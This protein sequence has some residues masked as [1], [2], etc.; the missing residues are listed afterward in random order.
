[1]LK[2]RYD[3]GVG[4]YLCDALHIGVHRVATVDSLASGQS[5]P[6]F[7]HSDIAVVAHAGDGRG[8]AQPCQQ[9]AMCRGGH[10]RLTQRAGYVIAPQHA[11][12]DPRVGYLQMGMVA[13]AYHGEQGGVVK[14]HRVAL[15][16]SR[17]TIV[18]AL[19]RRQDGNNT[20]YINYRT[21]RV[22]RDSF[23]CRIWSSHLH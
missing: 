5:L 14:P 20:Y 4:A 9:L 10:H 7:I 2:G 19:T 18:A 15:L 13:I 17:N 16:E 8:L 6:H 23:S 21:Q 22:H 12:L 1:M 11:S 3:D